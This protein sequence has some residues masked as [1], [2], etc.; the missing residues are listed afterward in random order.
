MD[1]LK[2]LWKMKKRMMAWILIVTIGTGN[3]WNT[4]PAYGSNVWP[5]K[6]TAPYYCLDGGKSWRAT[7]QYASYQYDTLP[8]ALTETQAIIRRRRFL[9]P[10]IGTI[11][12]DCIP[13]VSCTDR[14]RQNPCHHSFS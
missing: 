13:Y 12:R 5:Q 8:S 14:N 6:S 1:W 3:I 7:D 10:Y 4:I 11:D 2:K 9:R